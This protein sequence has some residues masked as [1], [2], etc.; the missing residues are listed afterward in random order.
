MNDMSM[1]KASA[2]S[3][4]GPLAVYQQRIAAGE[5]KSDP[6]Q[7]RVIKRLDQLWHELSTMQPPPPPPKGLLAGLARRIKPPPPPQRPRGLYIVGRVGRGK[8][9]VMDLF[10]SCAPVKLKERI[11]FLRFMQDVHQKLHDLKAANPGMTDPI[12]P[13]AK[14]LAARAHLLCFDEFQVNDIADAMILGRLFEALFAD[15]VVIV[16]TSN[17]EP[18]ELFQNRPGADAFKPFIAIIK[19]ELDTVELDSPRDYRRGRQQDR[20]TWIV[21]ADAQAKARLDEIF[22]RYAE[23]EQPKPVTLEFSG[24]TFEVDQAAGPVARF[25]FNSLCGKPRGPNDY[26]ALAKQFTVL[27][28]DDIPKMGQDEANLARRFITL[29]DALYDNGNLLFASAA[30]TPDQLFTTGEGADAF[31][32]T[33]SRLAE[34]SS[35]SWLEQGAKAAQAAHRL[36]RA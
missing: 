13:L 28:I 30:A 15:G 7:A 16:A 26:L 21:P 25:D 14:A 19:R 23:G 27:V 10:Y 4:Q 11:H 18:G 9:M 36:S 31:A 33:A 6:D 24:R 12:P 17:T 35:E 29:I 20:E 2:L 5:L 8:T 34:M 22:A 32:R 1:N 3:G